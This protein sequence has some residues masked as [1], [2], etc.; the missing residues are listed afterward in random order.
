MKVPR[1]LLH[2]KWIYMI[3]IYLNIMHLVKRLLSEIWNKL[4]V[5]Y[6]TPAAASTQ[7]RPFRRHHWVT[8]GVPLLFGYAAL[9]PEGGSGEYLRMTCTP[10]LFA[11]SGQPW[12]SGDGASPFVLC[13][14]CMEW[15]VWSVYGVYGRKKVCKKCKKEGKGKKRNRF[16]WG[17]TFYGGGGGHIISHI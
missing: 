9:C 5:P 14:V 7:N 13:S 12:V 3:F 10:S 2:L 6:E 15:S 11:F 16:I 17:K 4:Y 8:V 1:L